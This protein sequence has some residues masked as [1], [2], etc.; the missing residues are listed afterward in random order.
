VSSE[1]SH[2]DSY[3]ESSN[4]ELKNGILVLWDYFKE[5]FRRFYLF[6]LI[7]VLFFFLVNKYL[8]S[9]NSTYEAKLTFMTNEKTGGS[10][11]NLMTMA[12]NF[13]FNPGESDELSTEKLVEL[14][15]S[16]RIIG[17]ALLSEV[18]INGRR[19]RLINFYCEEFDCDTFFDADSLSRVRFNSR[20][21]SSLSYTQNKI[22]TDIYD[23]ILENNL[24][25]EASQN[26]II[27]I[28]CNTVSE[29]FSKEFTEELISALS[30][31]YVSKTIERQRSTKRL[32]QEYA[33]SINT[34]LSSAEYQLAQWKDKNFRTT[35]SKGYLEE[36]RL[37]RKVENL[38]LM[39]SESLKNLELA[40]FDLLNNT[41]VL[42]VIDRPTYPLSLKK[43]NRLLYLLITAFLTL[44]FTSI[45][46]T[47]MKIIRDALK[48]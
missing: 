2:R 42:Q 48:A 39:Y 16:R 11:S 29:K 24:V 46:I 3:P 20:R 26:G 33:D 13:G 40:K 22:L 28:K 37:L 41:P 45:L 15:K 6:I 30:S 19:D 25:T 8:N 10:L 21:L 17:T 18:E 1:S 31:F 23:E 34:E 35:K 5:L 32:V 7:G 9:K 47:V 38:A 4:S 43:P 12:S 14:L 27:S 36:L 44:A